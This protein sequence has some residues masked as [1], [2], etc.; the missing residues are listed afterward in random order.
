LAKNHEVAAVVIGRNEGERLERCFLSLKQSLSCVI[1]VDSGSK[2]NSV[3]LASSLD[4]NVISLD[5]TIAFTA[6]RARNEGAAFILENY[7]QVQYIQFVDGDCEVQVDWIET[8]IK[9]LN[10]NTA[11]AV[12]CGRRRER[13]PGHS[14]Y[15]QLCDIEWNTPVGDAL[16]CG[17]DALLR[18]N[19]YQQVAG[20]NGSLIAGE[21]PELCFRLR[22]QGWKIRRLDAEMTLHDATMTRFSQ[23][24]N[25]AKRAGYA[26]ASS[27][28]LHGKSTER[29]KLK[30]VISILIWALILPS[31]IF[32]LSLFYIGFLTGLLLYPLQISRLAIKFMSLEKGWK[33]AMLYAGSIVLAKFPQLCGMVKF[34]FNKF[35]DVEGELIEYK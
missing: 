20:Y 13:Y 19:A 12:A 8:A 33:V 26:Y 27:Y 16:A 7:P 9:F 28:N 35:K 32:L 17:G 29:F 2:D 10:E 3:Q 23:W 11:Y 14:V 24:W 1:Y 30:E 4:V 6:A 5:M 31:I 18:A 21:E 34:V 25:R 22:E 15:N